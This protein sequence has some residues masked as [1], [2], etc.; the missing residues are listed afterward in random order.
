MIGIIGL[1]ETVAEVA[2]KHRK[3]S[4]EQIGKIL[5]ERLS[6]DNYIEKRMEKIY[7]SAFVREYKKSM[8]LP[9]EEE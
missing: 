5:Q 4:D 1:K 2:E 7:K 3:M 6:K 9:V 8:S